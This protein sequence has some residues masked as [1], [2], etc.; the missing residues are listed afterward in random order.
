MASIARCSRVPF[1]CLYVSLGLLAACGGPDF[2][3]GGVQHSPAGGEGGSGRDDT[4]IILPNPGSTTHGEDGGGDATVDGARGDATSDGTRG[5]AAEG[6]APLDATLKGAPGTVTTTAEGG[7]G[8]DAAETD[9]TGESASPV[10]PATTADAGC[11]AGYVSC[12]GGCVQLSSDAHHCG[13]C[14]N[15]CSLLPNVS[16]AGLGCK[17]GHCAYQCAGDYADCADSGTGC[18]MS[19]QSTSHCG[20]CGSSCGN[21]APACASTDAGGFACTLVCPSATTNCTG[22]CAD[23]TS[24]R[25][26]CGGCGMACAPGTRC[27]GSH[28]VCDT[29]SGCNGCCSSATACEPYASESSTSC[30]TAGSACAPCTGGEKCDTSSGKC[31]C[32]GGQALCG[33]TC[34]NE[35]TDPANCGACGNQCGPG[36][37]CS[38]GRC[39][40]DATSGCSGCCSSATT[41]EPYTSQSS[42]SCGTGGRACAACTGGQK[43]DTSSGQCICPSGQTLCGGTCVNEQTD[44]ANCGACG[45]A[46]PISC[47]SGSCLK[48]VSIATSGVSA[49]TCAVLS[50]G[51]VRCWGLN[52]FGQVGNGLATLGSPSEGVPTP[53]AVLN[54]SNVTMASEG[55][56]HGCGLVSGGTVACWGDNG[57]GELG[58]GGSCTTTPCPSA[59]GAVTGLTNALAISANG[60]GLFGHFTCALVSGGLVYCWGSG[61]EGQLGNSSTATFLNPTPTQAH[62]SQVSAIATYSLGACALVS[63]GTVSCWGSADPTVVS[64]GPNAAQQATPTQVPGLTGATA[65]SAGAGTACALLAGGSVECWGANADGEVGNGVSSTTTAS[66]TPVVGLEGLTVRAVSVGGAHTCALISDGTVRCWGLNYSGQV[67]NGTVSLAPSTDI[68]TPAKVVGLNNVVQ[69]ATGSSFTCALLSNGAVE[70]W[71][72]NQFDQLGTGSTSLNPQPIPGLVQW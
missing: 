13:A 5:D 4:P 67:G 36:L 57:S 38:A 2:T 10:T 69:I 24:D 32:S 9:A 52:S 6:G 23:L 19:L 34:V 28:C 45:V 39:V 37:S 66:P 62:I 63:G 31:G 47:N 42:A 20:A 33:T 35:Q 54:L 11:P 68:L 16:A 70:C 61:G 72:D 30:G 49:T 71:G 7:K 56:V 26:N 3:A 25:K 17:A 18:A 46:C 59:A 27:T 21:A 41:C 60:N 53:R 55:F 65:I 22:T 48:A 12:N 64:P 44:P 15:D 8:A 50:D 29:T 14:G 51:T 58:N 43:C 1:A 40:C